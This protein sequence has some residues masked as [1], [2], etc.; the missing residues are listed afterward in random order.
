MRRLRILPL[1]LALVASSNATLA[2]ASGEYRDY[3]DARAIADELHE[4]SGLDRDAVLGLIGEA[5]RRQ[6]ILDAI[7]RP[8]ERTLTWAEYR[9]QFLSEKRIEQGVAFWRTHSQALERAATE[10]GVPAEIIVAI[11]GVETQYGRN[12]GRWR[13]LDALATLAFDHPPRAPFFRQQLKDFIR[14]KDS[15]HIDVASVK[16]SYAG[17]MG[18]PQFMP[19]SYRHVAVDFDGDGVIDLFDNPVDAI[20]SVAAYLALHGWQPGEPA[21]ARIAP[22]L[23]D[24]D[25]WT[26]TGLQPRYSA[27][28]LAEAGLPPTSCAATPPAEW[29]AD[30]RPEDPVTAWRLEGA[31][32][33][34]YWL[35]LR[36][37]HVI[38]RYNRSEKYALAVVQLA[39]EIRQRMEREAGDAK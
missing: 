16:G 38:T 12:K 27:G 10:Y 22:T 24:I 7:A 2:S 23:P 26:N 37:F 36:N 28:E 13:V 4:E 6:A 35:G 19:S 15:A 20:G 21:A 8:A 1:L 14:L 34:E 5:R 32:G 30:P 17:A 3:P 11:I 18:Y 31:N 9:P 39:R 29:C 33:P 25:A